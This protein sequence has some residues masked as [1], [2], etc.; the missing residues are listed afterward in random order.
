MRVDHLVIINLCDSFDN[1]IQTED[2][3]AALGLY[4]KH[5]D[6]TDGHKPNKQWLIEVNNT[7]ESGDA[8]QLIEN[9]HYRVVKGGPL[10]ASIDTGNTGVYLVFHA[11]SSSD[12]NIFGVK[13]LGKAENK[14]TQAKRLVS[15][16]T[17]LGI[18]KIKKLSLM[19]CNV[20][21]NKTAGSKNF[22]VAVGKVLEDWPKEARP[23]IAGYDSFVYGSKSGKKYQDMKN[24]PMTG[25]GHKQVWVYK[26]GLVGGGYKNVNLEKS[27]WSDKQNLETST[28]DATII[29]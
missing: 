11:K 14:S 20:T 13:S 12:P 1:T 5:F 8:K 4:D 29:H 7:Q 2:R 28:G 18:K 10:P 19:A 21:N 27:G 6:R 26:S 22:L 24:T 25:S 9:T 15:T 23:M 16:L 17:R 3:E